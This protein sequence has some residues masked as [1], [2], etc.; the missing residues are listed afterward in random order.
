VVPGLAQA[1]LPQ[2]SISHLLALH[3]F[4]E[5]GWKAETVL[6]PG[7]HRDDEGGPSSGRGVDQRLEH[8]QHRSKSR[9]SSRQRSSRA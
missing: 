1:A 4:H 5:L 9:W 7:E 3:R 6:G 2:H 8:R